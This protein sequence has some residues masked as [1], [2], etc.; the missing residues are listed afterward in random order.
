[1]RIPRLC[2]QRFILTLHSQV[3]MKA[4]LW[5]SFCTFSLSCVFLC[6][7][8]LSSDYLAKY[9]TI[10]KRPL[11]LL[12]DKRFQYQPDGC[13]DTDWSKRRD[14]AKA[15]LSE[16]AVEWGLCNRSAD[17][18]SKSLRCLLSAT[19]AFLRCHRVTINYQEC[20]KV[21]QPCPVPAVARLSSF[22]R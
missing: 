8:L 22:L 20:W 16:A 6:F 11:P 7:T 9:D 15:A 14:H 21:C 13:V 18:A 3:S 12:G 2:P 17:V 10:H 5:G 19:W 4:D 1:M